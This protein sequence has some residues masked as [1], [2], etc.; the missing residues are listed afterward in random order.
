METG[1]K[2]R[3]NQSKSSPLFDPKKKKVSEKEKKLKNAMWM[4]RVKAKPKYESVTKYKELGRDELGHLDLTGP[5]YL[6]N[7]Q[8]AKRCRIG[9]TTSATT[10]LFY[11][12][13]RKYENANA[14]EKTETPA[15]DKEPHCSLR[16]SLKAHQGTLPLLCPKP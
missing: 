1:T 3:A 6:S 9:P 12:F 14:V 8:H 4:W 11:N 10:T 5:T 16:A 2:F 15:I 7:V 13:K